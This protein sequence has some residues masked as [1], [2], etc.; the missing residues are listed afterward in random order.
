VYSEFILELIE[1]VNKYLSPE[2]LIIK[3]VDNL[4]N[5][6]T[7]QSIINVNGKHEILTLK[8][9]IDD[10]ILSHE[11]LHFLARK[12]IPTIVMMIDQDNVGLIG[13]ELQGY[14]EH[15]WILNEQKR[16]GLA[17][18]ENMLYSDI[19]ETIGKDKGDLTND[20]GRVL[21]I[22]N[23]IRTFPKVFNRNLEFLKN[24]N[25][26]SLQYANR[27][28]SCYTN[29]EIYSVFDCRRITVRA[30]KEWDKIIKENDISNIDLN[31]LLCA[32]PVFS[33]RQLDRLANASIELVKDGI[34][35]IDNKKMSY[36]FT[37][38]DNQCC[39]F[40]TALDKDIDTLE[41]H[42]NN[43]TLK[44]VIGILGLKHYIY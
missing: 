19:I 42:I 30:I 1:E 28:M 8:N 25:H 15:N 44:E 32:V 40:F 17:I 29:S 24:N 5:N 18:D 27:I 10:Y 13:A 34:N 12:N 16:R 38:K 22:C 36:L 7:A 31:I 39:Y 9:N 2:T 11:L 14:L 43:K 4:S 33:E 41:E 6:V 26:C 21:I 3:E 23:M 37:I 35:S 20:M